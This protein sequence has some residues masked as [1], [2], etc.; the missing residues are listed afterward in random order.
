MTRL[1]FI[2]GARRRQGR[3]SGQATV[4]FA[5]ILFPLLMVVAGI[6]YFGIG[7]NYWLDMNRIA[8]QGARQAVVNHWGP[9]CPRGESSCNNF[10]S[11]T[12]C[13]TVMGTSPPF[14]TNAR[15]TEVL[16]CQTRNNAAV[17]ICFP[18]KTP[19]GPTTDD[20]VIGDPV[21]VKI[22]APYTFFFINKA[23]ITLTARATMRLEQK[24]TLILNGGGP[25]C[26]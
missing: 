22:T 17:T 23:R 12:A 5:L 20:P 26:T 7:L 1:G 14:K 19:G 18:G 10:T 15:L 4:E 16:R 24:P 11:T 3:E 6:I 9:Q 2:C 25:T 8:N 13:S 21:Q